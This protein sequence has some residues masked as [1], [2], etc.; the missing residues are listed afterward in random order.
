[1][2]PRKLEVSG[3]SDIE[4]CQVKLLKIKMEDQPYIAKI[5]WLKNVVEKNL[6]KTSWYKKVINEFLIFICFWINTIFSSDKIL[7]YLHWD[8]LAGAMGIFLMIVS[9]K[10]WNGQIFGS[11]GWVANLIVLFFIN[12]VIFFK[13]PLLFLY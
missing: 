3:K 6:F 1:M 7:F 2:P 13:S 8:I 5:L 10:S 4:K 12:S 9:K 11:P